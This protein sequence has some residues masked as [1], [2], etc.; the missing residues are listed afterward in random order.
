M[1]LFVNTAAGRVCDDHAARGSDRVI[2]YSWDD[3]VLPSRMDTRHTQSVAK[4]DQ[5]S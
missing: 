3:N 1:N 5:V 2:L 4:N